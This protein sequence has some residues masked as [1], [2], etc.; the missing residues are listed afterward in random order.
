EAGSGDLVIFGGRKEA[1]GV[2]RYMQAADVLCLSSEN[3]GVPNVI[4]EAFATGLQVLAT[5]VG[6]I[7]EVVCD[8]FLGRLVPPGSVEEMVSAI[9]DLLARPRESDAIRKHASRF[10]WGKASDSYFQL[11]R[12]AA[13][14]GFSP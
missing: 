5:A 6:G 9:D 10:T 12:A 3:E 11:L 7:P 14:A 13:D 4:L 2:A 1:A 8:D